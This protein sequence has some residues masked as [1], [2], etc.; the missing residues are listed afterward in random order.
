MVDGSN[1][2]TS[3]A[4]P[5][6]RT[7]TGLTGGRALY[8]VMGD[9]FLDALHQRCAAALQL[10][11]VAY[12]HLHRIGDHDCARWGQV[13][14]PGSQVRRQ[15]VDVVLG[16]VEIHQPAVHPNPDID[17][18]PE[19]APCLLAEPGHLPSDFQTGL[20]RASHVVLV[21]NRVTEHRQQ[22]VTL[23]GAN[24]PLYLF[25]TCITCSR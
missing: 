25:T 10:E 5:Y 18:D 14:H 22:S 12:Q 13:R 2:C 17:L 7:L 24:V 11:V 8:A 15:P 23:G 9:R 19:P 1:Q 3:S 6:H 20:H 4:P 16:G 21:G